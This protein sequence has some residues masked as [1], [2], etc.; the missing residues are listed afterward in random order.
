[1]R[2]GCVI[3]TTFSLAATRN[4][5]HGCSSNFLLLLFF[6]VMAPSRLAKGRLAALVCGFNGVYGCSIDGSS[7]R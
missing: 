5:P 7:G 4:L 1:M 6:I 3:I 2:A